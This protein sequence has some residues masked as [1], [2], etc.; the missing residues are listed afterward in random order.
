MLPKL[1]EM[2]FTSP[3]GCQGYGVQ[4]DARSLLAPT[5]EAWRELS[6]AAAQH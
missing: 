1:R 6:A 3:L 4:G 2:G 5:M